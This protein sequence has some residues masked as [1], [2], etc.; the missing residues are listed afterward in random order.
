MGT[1]RAAK[2]TTTGVAALA[3]FAAG[4]AAGRDYQRWCGLGVGGIPNTPRGWLKVT[5]LRTQKRETR[6]PAVYQPLI[7]EPGD[8]QW[9]TDLPQRTGDRPRVAPYPVPHRQVDQPGT[10]RA[11]VAGLDVFDARAT[12][13]PDRVA[14]RMSFF[15][16]HNDAIIVLDTDN[17]PA[18]TRA[19][20]GE[21]AHIHPSDGSMHMIFSPSDA[22]TV[23]RSGWGERHPLAGIYPN[24]PLTYLLVYCPRTPSEA[25][26][27][28]RLLDAAVA[29]ATGAVPPG[30]GSGRT[31]SNS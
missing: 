29:Y 24:L 4:L 13:E 25:D 30:A 19:A 12:R 22:A 5:Y 6:D 28:G 18:V 15:E 21:T 8:G 9:L 26:V 14:Y 2:Y 20:H 3:A 31:D 11:R 16:R 7:G 1:Y 23:L 10:P 17:A 27:V